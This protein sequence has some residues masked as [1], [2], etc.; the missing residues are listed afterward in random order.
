MFDLE[1]TTHASGVGRADCKRLV[2]LSALRQ[3]AT[4]SVFRAGGGGPYWIKEEVFISTPL[5][6]QIKGFRN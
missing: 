4:S 1:S 6:A 5:K 2:S 3:E